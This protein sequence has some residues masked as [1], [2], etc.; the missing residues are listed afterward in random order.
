MPYILAL[1]VFGLFT[2][3]VFA[4]IVLCSIPRF[5]R[6]RCAALRCSSG[7][8]FTPPLS[9]F[10]P[11]HGIEPGLEQHLES[12]FTQDYPEYEILFCAR[13]PEDEGLTIARRV[14]A[15]QYRSP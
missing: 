8:D 13:S 4:G 14:A 12:F 10:K 11:L 7:P 3:T 1:A 15:R 5:L 2:S 6:E 9:I